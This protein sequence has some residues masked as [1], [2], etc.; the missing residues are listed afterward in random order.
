[1]VVTRDS[2]DWQAKNDENGPAQIT[3]ARDLDRNL[4][5]LSDQILGRAAVAGITR[6]FDIATT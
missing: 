5:V 4:A 2:T 3:I 1:M 6:T